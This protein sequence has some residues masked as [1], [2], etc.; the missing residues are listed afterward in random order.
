MWSQKIVP[1]HVI[2]ILR[3]LWA[4]DDFSNVFPKNLPIPSKV[5]INDVM[6]ERRLYT[7][8]KNVAFSRKVN[9]KGNM[10]EKR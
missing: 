10:S 4:N 8:D 5:D 9:I 3:E 7:C 2:L 1:F 6:T